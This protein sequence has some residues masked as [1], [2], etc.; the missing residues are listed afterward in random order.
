[1]TKSLGMHLCDDFP[2]DVFIVPLAASI[3]LKMRKRYYVQAKHRWLVR[4]LITP[5]QRYQQQSCNIYTQEASINANKVCEGAGG[6]TTTFVS[7]IRFCPPNHRT[8]AQQAPQKPILSHKVMKLFFLR[9]S[10]STL[11][12]T[13]PVFNTH[14]LPLDVVELLHYM[15]H[16]SLRAIPCGAQPSSV[17][18]GR[19]TATLDIG[20]GDTHEIKERNTFR[21]SLQDFF[22][23]ATR[24]LQLDWIGLA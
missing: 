16:L 10:S 1:M 12:S 5:K 22:I 18:K 3:H 21:L 20:L 23:T 13:S 4:K 24:D 2:M 17:N 6:T 11:V 9:L 14:T 7:R 15:H 8:T 19:Q